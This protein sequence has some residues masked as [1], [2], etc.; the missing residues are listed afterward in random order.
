MNIR[1]AVWWSVDTA[2]DLLQISQNMMTQIQGAIPFRWKPP[3]VNWY[4][5]NVY[6]AF[7]TEKRGS[8]GD[9]PQEFNW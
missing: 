7:Y 9:S 6:G 5:C 3:P 2:F 1:A 8:D 4:K